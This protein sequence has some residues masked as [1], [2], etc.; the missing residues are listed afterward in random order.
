MQIVQVTRIALKGNA[1]SLISAEAYDEVKSWL[2][3]WTPVNNY[4]A[5]IADTL[6]EGVARYQKELSEKLV[7]WFLSN[8]GVLPEH[9]EFTVTYQEIEDGRFWHQP[10][11][12]L[13]TR[14]PVPA[15]EP[16]AA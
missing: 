2:P 7:P 1:K 8:K 6:Q 11:T 15:K 14:F 16:V 13:L 10:S 4:K 3:Q 12:E 9:F 5:V